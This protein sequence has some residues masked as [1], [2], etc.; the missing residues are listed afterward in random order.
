MNRRFKETPRKRDG[1]T[2]W[3][4]NWRRE[5][6]DWLDPGPVLNEA[7][8]IPLEGS[9]R[10]IS[11]PQGGATAL[12]LSI[13]EVYQ[14]ILQKEAY[15]IDFNKS[16]FSHRLSGID[17]DKLYLPEI[18]N[19]KDVL[20]LCEFIGHNQGLIVVD[21]IRMIKEDWHNSPAGLVSSREIRMRCPITTTVFTELAG[22]TV[23]DRS[24]WDE[25]V[26]IKDVHNIWHEGERLGHIATIQSSKGSTEMFF[27][28]VSGRISD[29]YILARQQ[30]A[31]GLSMNGNF[32]TDSF[33]KKGFWN[34]VRECTKLELVRNNEHRP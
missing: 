9:L 18:V 13:V 8:Q 11:P 24:F 16:L 21:S 25:T 33:I 17:L 30:L 6:R 23:K 28:H 2:A 5:N 19:R 20:D 3:A 32:G 14:R 4:R 31:Q 22:K 27:S 10:I 7:F 12:A 34:Y 15:Y 1:Y 29:S 26:E